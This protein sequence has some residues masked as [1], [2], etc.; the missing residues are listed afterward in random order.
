MLVLS[1]S[2]AIQ[3]RSSVRYSDLQG[4]DHLNNLLANTLINKKGYLEGMRE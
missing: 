4:N 2:A 3:L 1:A